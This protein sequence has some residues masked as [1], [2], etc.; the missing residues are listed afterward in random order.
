MSPQ[1]LKA[2]LQDESAVLEKKPRKTA[3]KLNALCDELGI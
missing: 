3:Q 2:K 1:T